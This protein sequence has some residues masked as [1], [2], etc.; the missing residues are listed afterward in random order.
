VGAAATIRAAWSSVRRGGHCT[1]VGV[2]RKDQ[3]VVL[4]PL[5]IFHFARTLTSTVYGASDPDVD[6]PV[7]ADEVRSGAL[8]LETLVTHRISLDEVGDAFDRMRQGQGARS[9]IRIGN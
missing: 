2:G 1:V 4:N 3:Q 5:E 7:L 9:L 8:N 6:I